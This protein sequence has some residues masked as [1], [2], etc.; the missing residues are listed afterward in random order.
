M[1]RKTILMIGLSSLAVGAVIV[2]IALGVHRRFFSREAWL[3]RNLDT[4]QEV[5][6]R[7]KKMIA[8]GEAPKDSGLINE[9]EGWIKV[10]LGPPLRIA[11][12]ESRWADNWT[13]V[14]YDESGEIQA[15]IEELKAKFGDPKSHWPR[16][17]LDPRQRR[18][19]HLFAGE[20]V[21]CEHINGPWY[22]CSF[23]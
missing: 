21:T 3:D 6:Q 14:V 20:L 4:F 10:E 22:W 2:A 18:I 17:G 5:V 9:R 15:V 1:N 19:L 11:F 16:K 8:D 7:Y 12:Q 13:A 23:T